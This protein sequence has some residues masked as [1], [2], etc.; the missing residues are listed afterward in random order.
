M[1]A[2]LCLIEIIK[3]IINNIIPTKHPRESGYVWIIPFWEICLIRF[4][5]SCMCIYQQIRF[6]CISDL[7]PIKGYNIEMESIACMN[8]NFQW[9]NVLWTECTQRIYCY[10]SSDYIKHFMLLKQFFYIN[11][12]FGLCSIVIFTLLKICKIINYATFLLTGCQL[13][14]RKKF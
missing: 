4:I 7:F 1:N 11:V 3:V 10:I 8:F 5:I 2:H 6:S 9:N 13:N 12:S 14:I